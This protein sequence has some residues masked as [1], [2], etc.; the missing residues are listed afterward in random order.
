[1]TL[2][3]K[4]TK[5]LLE[6]LGANYATIEYAKKLKDGKK[7]YACLKGCRLIKKEKLK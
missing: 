6:I 5:R 2:T 3:D 7:P 4:Q 1:M